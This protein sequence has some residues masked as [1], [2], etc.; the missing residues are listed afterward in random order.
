M[1]KRTL[2]IVNFLKLLVIL[3]MLDAVLTIV[4]ISLGIAIELNPLMDKLIKTSN[5]AFIAIKLAIS[6]ISIYILY[7]YKQRKLTRYATPM[8]TYT[9][10]CL[11][12]YHL[13]GAANL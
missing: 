7:K 13:I 9:Y 6:Y 10:L 4:W 11:L 2:L 1:P 3:C 8:L 12:A 5:V